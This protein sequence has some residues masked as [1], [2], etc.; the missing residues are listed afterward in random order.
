[1]VRA[2]ESLGINTPANKILYE[3]VKA[4]EETHPAR[5]G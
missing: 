1:V 3:L 2:G 4:L 5:L